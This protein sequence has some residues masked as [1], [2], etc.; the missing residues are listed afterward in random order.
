M[1]VLL[2][3]HVER[4]LAAL[5]NAILAIVSVSAR[6]LLQ[7][8]PGG[9]HHKGLKVASLTIGPSMVLLLKCHL[10]CAQV[11]PLGTWCDGSGRTVVRS[12]IGTWTALPFAAHPSFWVAG[13]EINLKQVVASHAVDEKCEFLVRIGGTRKPLADSVGCINLCP[14]STWS[15]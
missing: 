9:D 14:A 3:V 6:S 10:N 2:K 1:C 4:L 15:A 12:A 5:L 13:D 11:G 8:C 7:L